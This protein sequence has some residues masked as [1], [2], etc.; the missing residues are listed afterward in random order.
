M[1][2]DYKTFYNQLSDTEKKA[3]I[4]AWKNAMDQNLDTATT[5]A[6]WMRDYNTAKTRNQQDAEY[7]KKQAELL[8][9]S[10]DIEESQ[11][12]RKA[13]A[14]VDSLKQSIAYLWS[15]WMPWVSAQRLTSLDWQIKEAE[16][17]YWETVSLYQN[18]KASRKLWDEKSAQAFERQMEDLTTKLNDNVDKSIQDAYNT[19]VQ[20]DNNGKLDTV[21][22]LE[23]FRNKMY[24]DLD[25][26][27]TWFTDASIA[28]LD[29]LIKRQDVALTEARTY[30][31]NKSTINPE[32]SV[33]QWYYVDM[34]GDPVI[35]ATT[36]KRIDIPAEAPIEPIFD[37]KSGRLITFSTWENGEIVSTVNQ[38]YD[39]PTF[40][41]STINNYAQLVA[42]GKIDFEDVPEEVRNTATFIESFAW[43]PWQGGK[44]PWV[45][46]IWTDNYGNDIYGSWNAE[47]QQYEPI[48]VSWW[49]WSVWVSTWTNLTINNKWFSQWNWVTLLNS[50]DPS[51]T[52]YKRMLALWMQEWWLTFDDENWNMRTNQALVVDKKTWKLIRNANTWLDIWTFQIHWATSKE[53][54]DKFNNNLKIWIG[55]AN[56]M[57]LNI[58]ANDLSNQDQQIIAHIGYINN[59]AKNWQLLKQLA[60]PNIQWNQLAS[61]IER[62]Q[63]SVKWSW[64]NFL[65]KLDSIS[66]WEIW[67]EATPQ[68]WWEAQN[69]ILSSW[70]WKDIKKLAQNL[71]TSIE[72]AKQQYDQYKTNNKLS[73]YDEWILASY[74]KD[75]S[76]TAVAQPEF[77]RTKQR[78][79]NMRNEGMATQDIINTLGWYVPT[80]ENKSNKLVKNQ[81]KELQPYAMSLWQEASKKIWWLLNQWNYDKAINELEN[82][83]FKQKWIDNN[84]IIDIWTSIKNWED[85]KATIKKYEKSFWPVTWWTNKQMLKFRE[86]PNTQSVISDMTNF[87]AKY[88]NG[89]WWTSITA[90]ETDFLTPII[91]EITNNP[92]NAIA[93][94]NSIQKTLFNELNTTRDNAGLPKLKAYQSAYD[95]N[96]RKKAYQTL[97]GEK[98]KVDNKIIYTDKDKVKYTKDSLQKEIDRSLKAKEATPEVW[99]KWL[100]DNNLSHILD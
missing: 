70:D 61:L 75:V 67:W 96:S 42:S 41:E 15:Q 52:L 86:D 90:G 62:I 71:W 25:S 27:I 48:K 32:M 28:Q 50:I 94:I 72:W 92:K 79:I 85:L 26:K 4:A 37:Q 53:A 34:N 54:W 98:K 81:L 21:Q 30:Q 7:S 65:K 87:I 68:A 56:D 35:S 22:E 77:E 20:A 31:T 83:S 38:V 33:A 78:F 36:G 59:R 73:T 17:T 76:W 91:A 69:T 55:I 44:A 66:W 3:F 97:T 49:A 10:E 80:P 8:W 88:R 2:W 39:T 29:Y 12:L 63:W 1:T 82:T 93:K 16:K 74:L 51:W 46:K 40:E 57:W 23:N 99:L 47:T 9:Q 13:K 43:L 24:Q 100:N 6:N 95:I 58:N 19:L 64:N 14:W 84:G 89:I 18:A 45:E 60:D 5:F 11:T